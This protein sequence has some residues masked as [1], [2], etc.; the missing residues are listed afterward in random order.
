MVSGEAIIINRRNRFLR[1]KE[2]L[3]N[4]EACTHTHAHTQTKLKWIIE[5][6]SVNVIYSSNDFKLGESKLLKR[7]VSGIVLMLLLTSM[8]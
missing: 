4:A 1:G 2:R 8:L 3:L 5:D 6:F 7:T